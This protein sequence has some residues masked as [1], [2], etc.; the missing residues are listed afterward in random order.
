MSDLTI[1]HRLRSLVGPDATIDT[2]AAGLAVI[3]PRTTAACALVLR[4]ANEEGWKVRIAGG[5]NWNPLDAPADLTLSSAGLTAVEEVR[6]AD[7]MA[8]VQAGV[9]RDT[10]RL[11]LAD[12]G[13][14]WPL[15]PP[16]VQ[17]TVGSI[18]ATATAGPLRSGFGG[19]RDHVLG[20]TVVTADG[21][22]VQ[23]GGRVVKNVAGFDLTKLATGSFGAFGFVAAAHLRLRSIPRAD[24]T[25]TSEGDRD[26]LIQEARS[27]LDAGLIPQALE[28]LAPAVL[29]SARWTLAVRLLGP[30][31]QVEADRD[32]VR[33]VGDR[34]WTEQAGTQ[35]ADL[36]QRAS[37]GVLGGPTT[38]RMGTVVDALD[39]A[40]DLIAHHLDD[41]LVT[42]S[43]A[44]GVVRWTGTAEPDRCRL[45]RHAAAQVEMPLTLERGPWGVRH[46]LGH[47]GA[48][49][50]GVGR[51][52]GS[53]RTTFDPAGTLVVP[54][55]TV[56]DA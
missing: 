5:G 7:L 27:I 6:S 40:I 18:I 45:L 52:M 24:V 43:V 16:G 8:T 22:V 11:T 41:D 26:D 32:F 46:A 21:R 33:G 39:H 28:L 3:A 1:E 55:G 38:I 25:L 14:W 34:A 10:L 54:L 44:P 9:D 53:L 36:W 48:Y 4:T 13:A 35:A 20:L 23:A 29:G 42:A 47:F 49:R 12:H 31:P 51:L 15:D 19:V 37:S 50:E 56:D 2:D 17:R 30:D